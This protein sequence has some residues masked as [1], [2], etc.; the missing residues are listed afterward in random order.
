MH[1]TNGTIKRTPADPPSDKRSV[2]VKP[3]PPDTHLACDRVGLR[4]RRQPLIVII[5]GRGSAAG[6]SSVF[7]IAVV[8]ATSGRRRWK[9]HAGPTL[10]LVALR[11]VERVSKR[12]M[13][14]SRDEP[15]DP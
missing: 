13:A 7:R 1:Q 8:V 3:S 5:L 11:V 12:A 2:V 14:A 15:S 4:E 9:W 6:Q 10:H